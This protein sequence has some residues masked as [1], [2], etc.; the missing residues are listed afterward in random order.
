M[1]YLITSLSV[2]ALMGSVSVATSLANGV[3]TLSDR[4]IKS[5]DSGVTDIKSLIDSSDLKSK[6]KI[7]DLFIKD[8]NVDNDKSTPRSITESIDSIKD[9]VRDIEKELK[10]IQY[11]IQY[12]DNI[13]ISVGGTRLYKFD[14]SY[15]RLDSKIRTLNNRYGTLKSLFQMRNLLVARKNPNHVIATTEDIEELGKSLT[16]I[17]THEVSNADDACD[18]E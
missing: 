8:I 12:N 11:R 3:Y 15:K 18:V 7:M 6:I 1:E 13:Y 4:I 9:A 2:T 16:M 10:Q 14:N 5:T 17:L